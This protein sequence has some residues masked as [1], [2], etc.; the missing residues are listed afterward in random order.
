MLWLND[1]DATSANRRTCRGHTL[2]VV[3]Q[4]A[5]S[6]SKELLLRLNLVLY[7]AQP[8]GFYERGTVTCNRGAGALDSHIYYCLA[9]NA[10]R[11]GLGIIPIDHEMRRIGKTAIVTALRIQTCIHFLL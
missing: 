1:T 10:R 7:N 8:L 9:R 5:P 2:S 3:I 4:D 6:W 11:V